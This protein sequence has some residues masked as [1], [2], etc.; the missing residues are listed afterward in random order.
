M[1][2]TGI[3]MFVVEAQPVLRRQE[4]GNNNGQQQYVLITGVAGNVVTFTPGLRASNWSS[5]RNATLYSGAFRHGIG[6]EDINFVYG[7]VALNECYACWIKGNRIIAENQ[8]TALSMTNDLNSLTANNYVDNTYLLNYYPVIVL[9]GASA[10]SLTDFLFLNN[11][12]HNATVE[13]GGSTVGVVFAYDYHR[14]TVTN[15]NYAGDYQHNYADFFELREGNQ[16]GTG[17]D[18]DTHG[19]HFSLPVSAT[20]LG[21]PTF[22]LR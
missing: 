13:G 17:R 5:N 1:L 10:E 2:T 15:D 3:S 6:I 18:D 22:P 14:D 21:A 20:I 16:W 7:R 8:N 11:I 19:S 4:A 12:V 9:E